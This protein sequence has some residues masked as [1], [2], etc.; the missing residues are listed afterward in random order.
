[1]IDDLRDFVRERDWEQFHDPKN[2]AMAV[3]SEAG[4]LLS[5]LRWVRG[6]DADAHCA[7]PEAR[8]RIADEIAD[9]AATLLMLVDRIGLDLPAALHAKMQ[10]NR[11]KYP[12]EEH[13]GR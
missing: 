7:D 9:V 11:A 6:E 13:R 4:E 5:E 10:K 3:A 1:M 2:L 8:A 12:A